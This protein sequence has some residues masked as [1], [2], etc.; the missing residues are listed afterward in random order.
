M[1]MLYQ[2]KRAIKAQLAT[3]SR[4]ESEDRTKLIDLPGLNPRNGLPDPD[5]RKVFRE[6]VFVVDVA[7][8]SNTKFPGEPVCS[9]VL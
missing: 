8:V 9:L 1:A 5:C 6:V 4:S 2:E 3:L 7:L